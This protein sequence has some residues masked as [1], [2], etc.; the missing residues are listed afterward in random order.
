MC[1]TFISCT[2]HVGKCEMLTV[3]LISVLSFQFQLCLLPVFVLMNVECLKQNESCVKRQSVRWAQELVV[4]KKKNLCPMA[5]AYCKGVKYQC[6][7]FLGH[8]NICGRDASICHHCLCF[9][10]EIP[11]IIFFRL[12][13]P[14]C[15]SVRPKKILLCAKWNE[16]PSDRQNTIQ[17]PNSLYFL[18]SSFLACVLYLEYSLYLFE[19]SVSGC[20]TCLMV[21]L[22]SHLSTVDARHA[23]YHLL[24]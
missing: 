13:R 10:R 14:P 11:V 22:Q 20:V 18:F 5:F 9:H 7:T 8:Y 1:Q 24:I 21:T 17:L 19:S 3:L 2:D 6:F 15:R 4:L 12:D 23:I 16:G